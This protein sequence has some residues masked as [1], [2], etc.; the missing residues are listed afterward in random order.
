M[1][2]GG[3]SARRSSGSASGSSA[4][5]TRSSAWWCSRPRGSCSAT[6]S[7]GRSRRAGRSGSTPSRRASGRSRPRR[8][9]PGR[10]AGSPARAP[11]PRA[12]HPR[13]ACVRF[14]APSAQRYPLALEQGLRIEVRVEGLEPVLID[15]GLDRDRPQ[16]VARLDDPDALADR[17]SPGLADV[18]LARV[19]V[20]PAVPISAV[21]GRHDDDH[22]DDGSD[23]GQHGEHTDEL[24]RLVVRHSRARQG[25]ADYLDEAPDGVP[26]LLRGRGGIVGTGDASGCG[27]QHR[28]RVTRGESRPKILG[29]TSLRPDP[30]DQEDRVGHQLAQPTEMLWSGGTDDRADAREP[31]LAHELWSA[32]R[33]QGGQLLVHGSIPKRGV[34]ETGRSRVRGPDQEED[35]SAGLLCCAHQDLDLVL[36]EQR[37]RGEGVGSEPADGAPR[38]LRLADHCLPVGLCGHRDIAA[39]AVGDDEQSSLLRGDADLLQRPPAGRAEALEAGE[40]WLHRHA[41]GTRQLEQPAAVTCD[42][43]GRAI[44]DIGEVRVRGGLV[45]KRRR[46][47]VKAQAYLTATLVDERREPVCEGLGR[48]PPL[49]FFF[50]PEPAEKRGTLPPGMKIRSPVRG[51]TPC[52][53]PRSATANLPKPVKFTSPPPWRTLLMASRTASTAWPASFLLP[54]LLSPA[55]T[56]RNSAFV[57]SSPPDDWSSR[58]SVTA[59]AEAK[60]AL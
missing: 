45:R 25:T 9:P 60:R 35:P 19:A 12:H 34:L 52:R 23:Q 42:R 44:T 51:F 14:P 11:R 53:G 57:T 43:R 27:D 32:L 5:D 20:L 29:L 4:P 7:S 30:R 41:G 47:R 2:S 56:S 33:H 31:R 17:L 15:A 3:S 50:S 16:R 18:G 49:T 21:G 22:Q 37:V 1:R 26:Q 8:R 13:P 10:S 28:R 24:I 54:I 59:C 46:I 58:A 48:Y 38:R 36:A 55:S 6:C 39:L 40:L